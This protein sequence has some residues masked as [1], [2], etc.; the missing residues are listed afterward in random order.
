MEQTASYSYL[1]ICYAEARV[2]CNVE[3]SIKQFQKAP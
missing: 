3:L 1:K 2:E